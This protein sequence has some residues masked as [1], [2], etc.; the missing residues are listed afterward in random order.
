MTFLEFL[1]GYIASKILSHGLS[2]ARDV[3]TEE[4]YKL[5]SNPRSVGWKS[6]GLTDE[7]QYLIEAIEKTLPITWRRHFIRGPLLKDRPIVIIGPSGV[8]KTLIASRI[9]GQKPGTVPSMSSGAERERLISGW[10]GNNIMVAPGSLQQDEKGGINK[11]IKSIRSK[12]SP[13]VVVIVVAGGYH[14]TEAEILRNTFLRPGEDQPVADNL[15]EFIEY[16]LKEELAYIKFFLQ[17]THQKIRKRIPSIVTIVNKRD[18]WGARRDHKRRLSRYI[19]DSSEY[20][21]LIQALRSEWGLHAPSNHDIFPVYTF[22]GGFHP[23]QSIKAKALSLEAAEA[24]AMVLRGLI[25]Y[26]YT[27]GSISF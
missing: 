8:G 11:V 12:K 22:G 24:D 16:C 2:F 20:G 25:F 9:A 7:Q 21:K 17:K 1:A 26:Q 6:D 4:L 14:A 10:Q 13:K 15:D 5:R 18:L 19:E 23:D 27:E 3:L